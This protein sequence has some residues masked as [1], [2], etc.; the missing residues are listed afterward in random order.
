M[1]RRDAE[2]DRDERRLAAAHRLDDRL[3]RVAGRD[4]LGREPV[5]RRDDAVRRTEDAG[6][7]EPERRPRRHLAGEPVV[8]S[9]LCDRDH[10]R[11]GERLPEHHRQHRPPEWEPEPGDGD[12][13]EHVH[14]RVEEEREIDR[15]EIAP[16]DRAQI[17]RDWLDAVP[18]DRLGRQP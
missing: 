14:H 10:H 11:V 13:A 18:L 3:D 5:R 7:P 2:R 16:A 8:D 1:E 12:R 4:R 17:S 6:T 15:E 9:D